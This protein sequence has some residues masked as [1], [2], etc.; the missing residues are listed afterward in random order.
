[1]PL[2]T[3]MSSSSLFEHRFERHVHTVGLIRPGGLFSGAAVGS[4]HGQ[5]IL[6]VGI[7]H[8]HGSEN[9]ISQVSCHTH[10]THWVVGRSICTSDMVCMLLDILQ[11]S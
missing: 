9:P 4:C 3:D 2:R 10:V 7:M 5:C 6:Q 8:M 1:M 11:Q